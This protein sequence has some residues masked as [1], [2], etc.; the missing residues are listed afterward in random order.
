M[1]ERVDLTKLGPVTCPCCNQPV[2]VPTLEMILDRYMLDGHKAAILRV[3][4]QGRGYPVSTKRILNAMYAD[5][6]DGGP[7]EAHMYAVMKV[8]LHDLRERLKGS[9]IRI[10]NVGNR[11]GYRLVIE[12]ES[13]NGC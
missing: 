13:E 10:E 8:R 7:S 1:N 4:W 5:D 9:G 11:R 12:G 6:P 2:S 3:I